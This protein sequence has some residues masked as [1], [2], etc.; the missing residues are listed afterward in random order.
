MG[1]NAFY[2]HLGFPHHYLP[3]F[4][5]LAECHST[6][7]TGG[8]PAS[9]P[10]EAYGQLFPPD[11]QGEGPHKKVFSVSLSRSLPSL[12]LCVCVNGLSIRTLFSSMASVP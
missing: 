10:V 8:R 11:H 4:E 12:K 1:S 9:T 6:S 3:F 7:H 5:A 2:E